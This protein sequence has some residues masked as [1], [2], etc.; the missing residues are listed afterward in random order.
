MCRSITTLRGLDPPATAD[1][2]RAAAA[3]YVR[4]VSG[5]GTPSSRTAAALER[6]TEE[7]AAATA[8]LLAGLPPRERPPA[9]LPPLRRL[10]LRRQP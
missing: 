7:V 1:E 5:V 3:Q 4:K 8:A 9:Q 10:A 2:V 6:A